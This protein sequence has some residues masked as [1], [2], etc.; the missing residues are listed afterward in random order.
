VANPH[1][2]RKGDTPKDDLTDFRNGEQAFMAIR[3]KLIGAGY[4]TLDSIPRIQKASGVR[5]YCPPLNGVDKR[6]QEIVT[7]CIQKLHK[8]PAHPHALDIK[9]S[10]SAKIPR[11]RAI[12]RNENNATSGQ[13]Y[14]K[15]QQ[16]TKPCSL[17]KNIGEEDIQH[18]FDNLEEGISACDKLR[19]TWTT[20]GSPLGDRKVNETMYQTIFKT[21][22][23]LEQWGENSSREDT[24]TSLTQIETSLDKIREMDTAIL[25]D[26][27]RG[28]HRV[29]FPTETNHEK[30]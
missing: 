8:F 5:F 9:R 2:W 18:Y 10:P 12:E 22:D 20:H 23:E 25:Q 16:D 17:L 13:I 4:R 28:C 11:S 21:A 6:T 7:N 24:L 15:T 27:E 14:C 30:N 3:P 26:D 1:P 19:R 29:S